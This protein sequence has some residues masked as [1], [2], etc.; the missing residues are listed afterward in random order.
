M[1]E[2]FHDLLERGL[3]SKPKPADKYVEVDVKPHAELKKRPAKRKAN[4]LEL[5]PDFYE[6]NEASKHLDRLLSAWGAWSNQKGE[7][8]KG[9]QYKSI[10]GVLVK[11]NNLENNTLS[12][13]RAHTFDEGYMLWLDDVILNLPI[14]QKSAIKYE[15]FNRDDR[16]RV[17]MWASKWCLPLQSYAICLQEARSMILDKIVA[18]VI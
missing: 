10:L 14:E 16:R 6:G 8:V 12:D 3:I 18:R 2:S 15:V 7:V 11:A 17:D 13:A 9:L 4:K 5:Y 1:T